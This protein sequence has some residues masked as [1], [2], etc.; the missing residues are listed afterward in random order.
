MCNFSVSQILQHFFQSQRASIIGEFLAMF[1]R[2]GIK[3]E[4]IN[5]VKLFIKH[6]EQAR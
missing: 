4:L 6:R 5:V 3:A 1:E 2:D